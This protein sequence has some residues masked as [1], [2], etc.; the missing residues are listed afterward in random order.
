MYFDSLRWLSVCTD[1]IQH[2]HVIKEGQTISIHGIMRNGLGL[3]CYPHSACQELHWPRRC[4]ILSRFCRS[5]ILSWCSLYPLV[6]LYAQRDRYASVDLV[7][8]YV[9]RHMV[10]IS[11]IVPCTATA[12][13]NNWL[14]IGRK[15]LRG[16]FRRTDRSCHFRHP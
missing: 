3:R 11:D 7:R 5:T 13:A 14:T 16:V 12:A 8:R 6:V 1:P 15:H 2:A 10:A 9:P 4:S